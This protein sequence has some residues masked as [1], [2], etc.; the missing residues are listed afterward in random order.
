VKGETER[1]GGEQRLV[2]TNE[3]K[4]RMRRERRNSYGGRGVYGIRR[5]GGRDGSRGWWGLRSEKEG[6]EE[7]GKTEREKGE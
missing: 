4:R 2:G 5:E 1:E 7:K 3:C 6:W